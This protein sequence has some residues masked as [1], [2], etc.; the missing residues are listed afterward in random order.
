MGVEIHI[1][2]LHCLLEGVELADEVRA[3]MVVGEEVG[4]VQRCSSTYEDLQLTRTTLP[5]APFA[6]RI[7]R[8]GS[9]IVFHIK[10]ASDLVPSPNLLARVHRNPPSLTTNDKPGMH[11]VPD[12]SIVMQ[13]LIPSP[14][15]KR[16]FATRMPRRRGLGA[17]ARVEIPRWRKAETRSGSSSALYAHHITLSFS[18]GKKNKHK[19]RTCTSDFGPLFEGNPMQTQAAPQPGDQHCMQ[20]GQ[21]A[22]FL[23]KVHCC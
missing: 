4:H 10:L 20:F 12:D 9:N 16:L 18:R 7:R 14:K 2:I 8:S 5:I 13:S 3:Q 1:V 6:V 23:R 15:K 22:L 11:F 21:K 17:T 19:P